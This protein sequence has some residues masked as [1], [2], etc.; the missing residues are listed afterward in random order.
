VD[1]RGCARDTRL[2]YAIGRSRQRLA[3][4]L[5]SAFAEGL[6]SEQ[7]HVHRLGLLFGPSLVDPQQL[8][9]DLTLRR[10]QPPLAAARHAWRALT[11]SLRGTAGL[12]RSSATPLLLV[13]DRAEGE[14]LIVGRDP[15]CDLVVTDPTVSRRHA[16]LTFRDGVWVLQDLASRNGTA[17]NG[18][19]VGRMVVHSGD[20]VA[21][22]AQPIHID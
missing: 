2:V 20:I 1:I 22:G 3:G 6:L 9:G 14:R 12:G 17:V 16:Q 15:T 5:N 8:I 4:V 13:L 7:T 11:A 10:R 21:L 18:D 19:R